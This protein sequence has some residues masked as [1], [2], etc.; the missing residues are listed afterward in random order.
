MRDP[1]LRDPRYVAQNF[2]KE[3]QE[4]PGFPYQ[5]E[6]RLLEIEYLV[7]R[8]R[9]YNSLL[10]IGCGDGTLIHNLM[11]L[12]HIKH[13]HGCD[14]SEGMLQRVHPSVNTMVYDCCSPTELPQTDVTLLGAVLLY[15]FEDSTIEKLLSFIRSETLFVRMVCT[16]K[17]ED[18]L[19]N[20]YSKELGRPYAARYLTIPHTLQLLEKFYTVKDV[21][22]IYPDEIES[23]FGT[24][25]FY[26]EAVPRS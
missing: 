11:N 20:V 24:K 15:V 6:R 19:V 4:Y 16:L 8:V 26:F 13:F 22:R 9:T 2:W 1:N 14:I 18:E 17:E 21:R 25:Q 5:K 3:C 10:D 7:P 12:T 23:K